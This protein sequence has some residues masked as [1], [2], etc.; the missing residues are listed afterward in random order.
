AVLLAGLLALT[1]NKLTKARIAVI[2]AAAAGIFALVLDLRG[3]TNLYLTANLTLLVLQTVLVGRML[4][5]DRSGRRS[6][7][8]AKL[9]SEDVVPLA[10]ANEVSGCGGKASRLAALIEAGLPVPDG[11]VLRRRAIGTRRASGAWSISCRHR[12]LR[13][14][15]RLGAE[16]VAVRSSGLNEDGEARSYAGVFE[17]I[18]DVK[19]DDLIDAIEKVSDSLSSD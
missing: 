8:A 6:R 3:G 15:R 18:L 5:A 13:E 14:H 10:N 16:K 1:A 19:A 2:A 11:F 7:S 12:I 9:E 4:G 17:S